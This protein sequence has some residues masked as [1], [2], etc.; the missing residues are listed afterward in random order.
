MSVPST[1]GVAA[2]EDF[3]SMDLVIFFYRECRY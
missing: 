2:R 1:A 3:M